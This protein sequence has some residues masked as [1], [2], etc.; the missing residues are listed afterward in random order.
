MKVMEGNLSPYTLDPTDR[1]HYTLLDQRSRLC[2]HI[3]SLR[4]I[5]CRINK[6]HRCSLIAN[7]TG[8]SLSA[9]GA[10]AAIVGLSLSP[11]T[12]GASLLA[13]GV[14]LG[15]AATGGAVTVTSDLLVLSNSREVKKAKEIAASCHCQMRE[16]MNCLEFLHRSQG[17]TDPTLWQAESN[18]SVSLYNSV[19]FL[20][21]CGSQGFLVP[22]YTE[23]VTKVSH[24]VLK[25]K[26]Q[27]LA[28]NLEVCARL[29][30]EVCKLLEN[31]KEFSLKR[32]TP[33]LWDVRGQHYL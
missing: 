14:G 10:I 2:E 33:A 27:K 23:E 12:L 16:I 21:F 26:V 4:E 30:D 25:A 32:K 22:E 7:L 29:M 11:A 6:L 18:A 31:R 17:P 1:F 9:V 13:S 5:S 15:V 24:A 3:K 28:E 8:C 19:C 20:V